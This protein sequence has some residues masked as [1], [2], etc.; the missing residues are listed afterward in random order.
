M[1]LLG[2]DVGTG[3][4]KAVAF[5]A[6]TGGPLG[7]AYREYPLTFRRPGWVE[8]DAQLVWQAFQAT[9][10][11][12]NAQPAVGRDPVEALSFSVS[13]DDLLPVDAAGQP[14]DLCI[15]AADARGADMLPLIHAAFSDLDLFRITGVPLL[16]MFPLVRLLWW[17]ANCPAVF[18]AAH[19]FVNWQEF[20]LMQM[21]L[22]PVTDFTT[23]ARW[24]CFDIRAQ[25]WSH[26]ICERLDVPLALLPIAAPSGAGIGTLPPAH[27]HALGFTRPVLAVAGAFD[28]VCAA[29]GAGLRETGIGVVG[30]GSWEVLTTLA[31]EPP[32]GPDAV[33]QGFVY[34]RHIDPRFYVGLAGS[35]GGGAVLRWFRDQ[36]GHAERIEAR[37]TGQ[38]VYDLLLERIPDHPT[39]I[40]VV[41]HLQGSHNPWMDPAATGAILGVTVQTTR[42]EVVRG[43]LEGISYE[44]RLNLEGLGAAGLPITVVRATGGGARSR[45]WLQIKADILG[46]PIETVTTEEAGCLAAALLAGVGAGIYT[47]VHEPQDRFVD[48][49]ERFLPDPDRYRFYSERYPLYQRLYPTLAP[50]LHD[51]AQGARS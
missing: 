40:M 19:K 13:A 1:S 24:C 46:L 42:A 2:V 47:T 34:G 32:V 38:D 20:L 15:M 25:R 23:A 7:Q 17:R 49:R 9:V 50:L 48:V 39:S 35:A 43:I 10:R 22:P 51:M 18:A 8:L 31:H 44:L 27:A 6:V 29:V 3:G 33:R 36:F 28:Q 16:P 12:V 11:E 37:T 14:L 45:R 30:T 41:P 21:D 26:T 4:V 5:D